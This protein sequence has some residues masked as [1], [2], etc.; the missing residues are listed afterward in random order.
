MGINQ[1]YPQMVDHRL[2]DV[3][4]KL[5]ETTKI[6]RIPIGDQSDVAASLSFAD[7]MLAIRGYVQL[8]RIDNLERFLAASRYHSTFSFTSYNLERIRVANF[9]GFLMKWTATFGDF[10]YISGKE[11]WLKKDISSNV[12]RISFFIDEP[13]FSATQQNIVNQIIRSVQWR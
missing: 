4:F 8:W 11:Y 10:H 5:P 1:F 6:L 7:R 13:A 9:T 12:L 3:L 2:N